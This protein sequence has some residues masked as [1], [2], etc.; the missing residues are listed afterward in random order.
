MPWPCA[1]M[2]VGATVLAAVACVAWAA[3]A[4]AADAPRDPVTQPAEREAVQAVWAHLERKDCVGAV[5][6]LNEGLAKG[7]PGVLK[8]AGAMYEEG[9]CLSRNWERAAGLFQKAFDA[10]AVTAGAR[11]AAGHATPAGGPDQAAALWWALRSNVAL[12]APCDEVRPLVDDTERFVA[13]LR[14]WPA[15]RLDACVYAAAVLARIVADAHVP[16]LAAQLGLFGTLR[17]AF[18]PAHGRA[19]WSASDVAAVAQP[20]TEKIDTLRE[21]GH[22]SIALRDT[23]ARDRGGKSDKAAFEAALREVAERALKRHAAPPGI[24]PQWRVELTW[25]LDRDAR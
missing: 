3:P 25:R 21:L 12:P 24:D 14:A 16:E 17:L 10:G 20:G 1:R 2:H 4:S 11:L 8:L 13:A 15:P 18:V 22:P 5:K 9:L 19:E 23:T 6:R 7:L